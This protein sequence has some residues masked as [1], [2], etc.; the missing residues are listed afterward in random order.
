[1]RQKD[2]FK[3]LLLVTV[4]VLML[5]PFL[6]SFSQGLTDIFNRFTL[7]TWLQRHVVPFEAKLVALLL[8]FLGIEGL[9]TPGSEFAL[10][11]GLP[12]GRI[13]PVKLA[14]NC[15]GWQSMLL[16][17]LT[18]ATGL[19]GNYTKFSKLNVAV[20]GFLGT[21]LINLLRMTAITALM[22][23]RNDIAARIVHDYAAMFVA[24]AWM[25]FFW[26]FS[27]SYVLESKEN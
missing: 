20:S 19:R 5:L 11:L 14:W 4:L 10:L 23:Y 25:V 13:L 7:Y 27:Y 21:F 16:L 15:L 24:L 1:M 12:G 18:Y 3:K 26:W 2:I 22:Y 9:V 6:V 17:G 8:S